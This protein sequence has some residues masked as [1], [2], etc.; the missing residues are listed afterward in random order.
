M[1]ATRNLMAGSLFLALC[2]ALTAPLGAQGLGGV[3]EKHYT[4]DGA[5]NGSR[6]GDSVAGAGDVNGDGFADV[7]VGARGAGSAYVYSGADGTVLRRFDGVA[8][9]D[10]LGS[11]VA[12]A[13]DVNR[14]GF[15]DVIVGAPRADAGGMDEAGS[16]YVYSGKDGT[17]LWQ[18]DGAREYAYLGSSVDGAG[19]V[20]RDGFADLIVVRGKGGREGAQLLHVGWKCGA[21]PVSLYRGH[22]PLQ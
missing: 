5:A 13:G 17:L 1:N 9:G 21:A 11:S 20:N 4:F 10:R 12:G 8:A 14:D 18:F 22:R 16:A 7:I 3:F 2:P 19:D 6:F 15:A